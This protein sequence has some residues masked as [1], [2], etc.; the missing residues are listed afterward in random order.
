MSENARYIL[1]VLR[2]KNSESEPYFQ[3]FEYFAKTDGDTVATAL[4]D[5]NARTEIVDIDGNPAEKIEWECSCLQKK[6]GACAMIVNGIPKLACDSVLTLLTK[7]KG[8]EDR[9]VTVEPLRKFPKVKDLVVVRSILFENLKTIRAWLEQDS[10]LKDKRRDL[11]YQASECLQCGCC[12]EICPNF[13]VGGEF[14]SMSAIPVAT[15]LLAETDL[16]ERKQLISAYLEHGFAGCGK[17]LACKDVCPK[18]IDTG[19]LLVKA[20]AL[21]LWRRK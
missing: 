8:G 13:Y 7:Q 14:F 18:H 5:I 1:K 11:A 20:N 6:C 12:L 2:R 4:R 15:R 3:S 21:S 19:Y 9:V 10:T 16:K 17:S